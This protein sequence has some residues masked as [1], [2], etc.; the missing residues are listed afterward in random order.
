MKTVYNIF[1]SILCIVGTVILEAVCIGK[2][3]FPISFSDPYFSLKYDIEI[4]LFAVVIFAL[5]YF[6][7]DRIAKNRIYFYIVGAFEIILSLFMFCL[8]YFP[9]LPINAKFYDCIV[10]TLVQ[11]VILISRVFFMRK[12]RKNSQRQSEDRKPT[13]DSLS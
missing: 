9:G 3:I 10:T 6:L 5:H 2:Y 11:F 7:F 13:D 8:L 4:V 12:Q 1:S